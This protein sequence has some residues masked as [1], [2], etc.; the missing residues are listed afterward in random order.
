[1]EN[2]FRQ[3]AI[4]WLD[5]QDVEQAGY[6]P[7]NVSDEMFSLVV[8]DIKKEFDSVFYTALQESLERHFPW[9]TNCSG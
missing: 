8:E 7:K 9:P 2:K 6:D 3:E 5:D 4:Y 1:M